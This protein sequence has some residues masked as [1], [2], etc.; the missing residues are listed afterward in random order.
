MTISE[1][2]IHLSYLQE[3]LSLRE[4]EPHRNSIAQPGF[5]CDS[6]KS[7]QSSESPQGPLYQSQRRPSSSPSKIGREPYFSKCLKS[8]TR[9]PG[10]AGKLNKGPEKQRP[11]GHPYNTPKDVL[12][13]QIYA[14]TPISASATLW[15]YPTLTSAS[16][17]FL[18]WC[19]ALTSHSRQIRTSNSHS[20]RFVPRIIK[21]GISARA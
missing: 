16:V 6:E 5:H 15:S 13:F 19:S 8:P 9:T 18:S 2:S 4:V 3:R 20:F 10:N 14:P 17:K 21:P 12:S 7:N 1:V 11:P